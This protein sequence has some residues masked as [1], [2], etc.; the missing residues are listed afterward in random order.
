MIVPLSFILLM[1]RITLIDLTPVR[2]LAASGQIP[3]MVVFDLSR[4]AAAL[5]LL[6]FR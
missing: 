3:L 6:V 4:Y 2:P 5:S 1:L